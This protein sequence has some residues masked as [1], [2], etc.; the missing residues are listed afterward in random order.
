MSAGH[1][2]T[3]LHD[4][5]QARNMRDW[6]HSYPA[7][8]PPG[9]RNQEQT[10]CLHAHRN[11]FLSVTMTNSCRKISEIFYSNQKFL[12]LG[13]AFTYTNEL[14][15]KES[16]LQGEALCKVLRNGKQT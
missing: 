16:Y 13:L 10:S 6:E 5:R 4:W 8:F 14:A 2:N 9:A 3:K 7:P 11:D 12:W 15:T 1:I